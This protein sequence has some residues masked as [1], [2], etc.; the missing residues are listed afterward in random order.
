MLSDQQK[1]D[2]IVHLEQL[3]LMM[4][5][6][7]IKLLTFLDPEGLPNDIGAA[8]KQYGLLPVRWTVG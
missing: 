8:V 3:F 1:V 5:A 2:V 7:D 6:A 4:L